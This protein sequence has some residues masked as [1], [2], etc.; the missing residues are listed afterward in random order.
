MSRHGNLI[1]EITWMA[2]TCFKLV[3]INS[4]LDTSWLLI[5]ETTFDF[6]ENLTRW[7]H[8][9]ASI[10]FNIFDVIRAKCWCQHICDFTAVA[11]YFSEGKKTTYLIITPNSSLP[12]AFLWLL[13]WGAIRHKG[14]IKVDRGPGKIYGVP[15]PGSGKI[16]PRKKVPFFIMK[17]KVSARHIFT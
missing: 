6:G 1:A 13:G 11:V 7:C 12:I 8:F 9:L 2:K 15:W 16:S 14:W 3:Q 17:K 10:H 4:Y 5:K